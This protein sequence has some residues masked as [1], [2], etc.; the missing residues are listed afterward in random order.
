MRGLSG[1][2]IRRGLTLLLTVAQVSAL[3]VGALG[4]AP[5]AHTARWRVT[6]APRG[7]GASQAREL[8]GRSAYAVA[9]PNWLW[10]RFSSARGTAV[11]RRAAR[12]APV[13]RPSRPAWTPAVSRVLRI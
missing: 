10:P 12:L 11:A 5:A 8:R 7:A 9:S 2:S 3:A 1:Q 6:T 13:L 4:A